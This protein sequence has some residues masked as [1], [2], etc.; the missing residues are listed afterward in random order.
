LTEINQINVG[1][2]FKIVG[3]PIVRH[4]IQVMDVEQALLYSE[5]AKAIGQNVEP[6]GLTTGLTAY[7]LRKMKKLG[8]VRH[9]TKLHRWYLTRAAIKVIT[10][11]KSFEK[12]CTVYDMDDVDADGKVVLWADV[13]S[14]KQ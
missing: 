6:S 5:I 4:I 3:N 7:Y 14:R 13:I 2:L 1:N 11:V 9:D 8:L 12:F 10:V